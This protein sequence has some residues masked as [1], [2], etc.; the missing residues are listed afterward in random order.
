M[1]GA[2]LYWESACSW[3]VVLAVVLDVTFWGIA[4]GSET[5]DRTV[6]R[7]M[8]RVLDAEMGPFR[9]RTVLTCVAL[10]ADLL[11]YML[12]YEVVGNV[13]A[14]EMVNRRREGEVKR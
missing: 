7:D 14:N 5:R 12:C 3:G 13:I 1:Q 4:Y 2:H 10:G 11:C 6:C 9:N 8:D